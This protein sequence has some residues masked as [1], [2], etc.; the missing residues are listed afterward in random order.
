[1]ST[2]GVIILAHGSRYDQD[3][4]AKMEEI[5]QQIGERLGRGIVVEWAAFQ[6]NSP[7]LSQRVA[8]MA[9]SGID[10]IVV[11]PYFLFR[12]RHVGQDI[13]QELEL[14]KRQY[15]NLELCLAENLG[16]NNC[17]V[18]VALDRIQEA[19]ARLPQGWASEVV[20]PQNIEARSMAI[21]EGLLP[22]LYCSPQE[23][24]IIKRI[25]HATGDPQIAPLIKFHPAAVA[26]GCAAIRRGCPIF[27]DV[28]MVAVGI[29]H[30][31]A[32]SYGCSIYCPI[33]EG[34][35]V[36]RAQQENTTRGAEGIFYLGEQINGAII[37]I[38]NSP[39]ALFALLKLME[40]GDAL[41]ALVVGMPVGLVSAAESKAQ[42]VS[43]DIPYITIKGSRGGSSAACATIN[44]LLR[45]GENKA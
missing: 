38:G 15:G 32:Q 23:S 27:T 31:R 4:T 43:Q 2:I 6:F 40:K 42:L 8:A 25:I 12:G 44:A 18:D 9:K 35:V 45:L 7:G 11:A 28:N 39:T 21:I 1:M 30:H 34:E 41:P 36:K 22:P 26:M 3:F 5:A 29:D 24:E 17:L 33:D 16:V 37:A 20:P 19:I 10:Q 14:I 13:P